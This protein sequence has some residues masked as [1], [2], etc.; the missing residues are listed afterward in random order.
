[1]QSLKKFRHHHHQIQNQH[2]K[3]S[4]SSGSSPVGSNR[5]VVFE[6]QDPYLQTHL[7]GGSGSSQVSTSSDRERSAHHQRTY[8]D[9]TPLVPGSNPHGQHRPSISSSGKGRPLNNQSMCETKKNYTVQGA[10]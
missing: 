6:D 9:R 5:S 10:L 1:M 7:K 8:S 2:R 3:Q 4:S